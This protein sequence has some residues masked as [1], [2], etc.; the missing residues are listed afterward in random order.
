M[1]S[2]FVVNIRPENL[3]MSQPEKASVC[4]TPPQKDK[5]G[6]PPDAARSQAYMIDRPF[7]DW[8]IAS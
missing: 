8:I 4:F 6:R 5:L 1:K 3:A 2:P 7:T